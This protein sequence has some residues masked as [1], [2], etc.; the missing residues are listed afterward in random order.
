MPRTERPEETSLKVTLGVSGDDLCLLFHDAD[1]A[2]MALA[3]SA[4]TT[5]PQLQLA[6]QTLSGA[7]L[8]I[9]TLRH[10]GKR[11]I[12]TQ[13]PVN[14]WLTQLITYTLTHEASDIHLE[15]SLDSLRIRVRVA[16]QL[17]TLQHLSMDNGRQLVAHIKVL[18]DLDSSEK[19]RPQDGR[20]SLSLAIDDKQAL[21]SFDF[22][23]SSCAVMS[24]EKLVIR[25]LG[26]LEQ[27]SALS[28]LGFTPTQLAAAAA[29][30]KSAQG[31][32]LVTGPTGSGK[33]STLY[34]LL[35]RLNQHALNICTVEDPI[36][37]RCPGVNQ[38]PVKEQQQMDFAR[39]LRTLLRQDPDVL[40]VGEIRDSETARVALQAAQTG[41][42][43]LASL[44]TR[45]AL[46]SFQRLQALGI[47]EAE[48]S[49][50]LS[51]I[52]SQRLL[53]RLCTACHGEGCDHCHLGYRGQ[54]ACFEVTP[55]AADRMQQLRTQPLA[56]LLNSAQL[57]TLIQHAQLQV[58][59][60][61]TS[62][63]Q[64]ARLQHASA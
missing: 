50:A 21:T 49:S 4:T 36:E 62:Q 16:G 32:I 53:R 6:W 60:G 19:R 48:I 18:A 64:A 46:A 9:V 44:H 33:T 17:L 22:R 59:Q 34:S 40:M 10:H 37:I 43:V 26:R 41:H 57:P 8:I 30:L 7:R 54:L 13:A 23:V 52:I 5:A 55:W 1:I 12:N 35:Q 3:E 61:L 27:V 2:V 25:S 24:G 28:Q 20:F 14:Q 58:Q 47:P 31:L 39:I 51:L 45:G 56:E 11:L 42:L 15:P 29:A 38:V 63:H